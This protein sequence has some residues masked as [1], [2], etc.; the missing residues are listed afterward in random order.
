MGFLSAAERFLLPRGAE[1]AVGGETA[2]RMRE[3]SRP[4][5]VITGTTAFLG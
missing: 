1:E 5:E 4:P 3:R 2:V